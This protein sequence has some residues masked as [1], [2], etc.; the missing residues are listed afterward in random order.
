M[1]IYYSIIVLIMSMLTFIMYGADKLFARKNKRRISENSLFIM[2]LLFG[3]TGA[4]IGTLTFNHKSSNWRF[5]IFNGVF[6]IIHMM[7][8]LYL[9][10]Q[11]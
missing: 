11:G 3:A 5:R 6:F 10:N 9:F 8:A 1:L 2:A 4:I 7:I